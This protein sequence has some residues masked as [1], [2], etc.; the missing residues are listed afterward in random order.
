MKHFGSLAAPAT[1]QQLLLLAPAPGLVPSHFQ[2]TEPDTD[3]YDELVGKMQRLRGSVY[4]KDGAIRQSQL[5]AGGRHV[6]PSDAASWH[7]LSVDSD[8]DVTGCAR[9]RAHTIGSTFSDL[10]VSSAALARS[11]VWGRRFRGAVESDMA[12]ARR[13]QRDYAEVGGWAVHE[14]LRFTCEALRIALATYAL[15][16]SLGGCI[17]VTTATVRNCSSRILRKLGGKPL[18]FDGDEIPSYF[19]PQYGCEMEVLRFESNRPNQRFSRWIECIFDQLSNV[20][21]VSPAPILETVPVY[22]NFT[23]RLTGA[24][25]ARAAAI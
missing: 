17:G 21:V 4:L 24:L 19:D 3:R 6:V 2:V 8:G 9:Y 23:E 20:P 25:V 7:V 1:A 16:W 14:S 15:A 18:E 5:Q 22:H 13:S 10:G 12:Q 11:D